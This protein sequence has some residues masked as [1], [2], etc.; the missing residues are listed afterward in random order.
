MFSISA[1]LYALQSAL[2]AF[3]PFDG[4]MHIFMC[5]VIEPTMFRKSYGSREEKTVLALKEFTPGRTEKQVN[6]G[7]TKHAS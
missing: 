3:I 4:S 2:T 6:N 5:L 7:K 1:V